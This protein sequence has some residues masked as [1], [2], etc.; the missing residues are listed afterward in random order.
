VTD[1]KVFALNQKLE[2]A[3]E[4]FKPALNYG[5]R[6]EM[7][8]HVYKV[9]SCQDKGYTIVED[10]RKSRIA[11]PTNSIRMMLKKGTCKNLGCLNIEK[12][13]ISGPG[14]KVGVT[15]AA[16][17]AAYSKQPGKSSSGQLKGQPVGTVTSGKDGAQYKKIQAN[18]AIWVRVGEG[19]VH[20][21]PGAEA[22]DP[23]Q[24]SPKLQSE[25]QRV[26]THVES[27]VHPDDRAK[28]HKMAEDWLH[29]KAKFYH[30]Q[31]AHNTQEVDESG[32]P[33]QRTGVARSTM[34][35]VFTQ[36]DKARKMFH[37]L[38]EAVKKSHKKLKG[39]S[40]A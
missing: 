16:A 8:N 35:K 14:S 17:N 23:R 25:F 15:R 38:I 22:H 26:I 10:E 1:P 4:G 19:T 11:Y 32:K 5:E 30:M 24:T 12:A 29:E 27:K 7:F 3:L 9:I 18:P 36:G 2:K 20:H 40:N 31:H 33:A 39:G 21:E 6:L 13:Q 37:D 34:D 28:I